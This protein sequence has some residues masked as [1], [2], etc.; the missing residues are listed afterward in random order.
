[1]SKIKIRKVI[2]CTETI[3]NKAEHFC[4]SPAETIAFFTLFLTAFYTIQCSLLQNVLGLDVLETITWGAQM[5]LGHAKHPPLS[6]W[7]GYGISCLGGHKDWI[8]YLAAQCC[9]A[10]SVIYVF[11]CARL[12]MD[13]YTSGTAALLLYFLFYYNPSESRF[14][15]YPL[16]MMLVPMASFYFFR[17]MQ[18]DKWHNW[19]LLGVLA[20]L[21]LLNK[22]SFGLVMIAWGVIFFRRRENLA[23]LKSPRPYAALLLTLL[24]LAPHLNW[25][26]QNNFICF[27]HVG[28]RLNDTYNWY[29]PLVTAATAIYPYAMMALI[30]AACAG[31][32][33][34]QLKQTAISKAPAVDCLLIAVIPAAALVV[35]SFFGNIIQM[36]FCTMAAMAAIGLTAF[37]PWKIDRRFFT[38]LVLLLTIF[39]LIMMLATT[40]DSLLSSRPRLHSRPESYTTAAEKFYRRYEPNRPIPLVVG[41]R[42]EA[43]LLENY[44]PHRPPACELDDPVFFKRYKEKMLKEGALLI[45]KPHLFEQFK[46]DLNIKHLQFEKIDYSY[47]ALCGKTKRRSIFLAYLPPMPQMDVK[48]NQADK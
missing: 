42:F 15:T 30:L 44:L 45:G 1:M 39:S 43:T 36:W 23:K 20:A 9:T 13:G 8:M 48:N 29:T 28:N 27:T 41:T 37:F 10:L 22:Y 21:G 33:F 40:L 19:L 5:T 11:K 31:I 4:K 47:R 14:C 18:D 38:A 17:A 24:L 7:L 25:L 3:I 26:R 12:F 35:L 2:S 6:G 46:K 32:N 16:E 34:R